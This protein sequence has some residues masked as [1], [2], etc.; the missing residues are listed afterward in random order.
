[1][2]QL[3]LVVF[4]IGN[5]E[6]FPILKAPLRSRIASNILSDDAI[7][8]VRSESTKLHDFNLGVQL[9]EAQL[10]ISGILERQLT[11]VSPTSL[12]LLYIA[13][14]LTALSPCCLSLLPL[15]LG[16]LNDGP[17]PSSPVNTNQDVLD[18]GEDGE[19]E[20]V[21][22][23]ATTTTTTTNTTTTVV[24]D[25]KN[26]ISVVEKSIYYALGFA[27]ALTT[28]GF[29]ATTFGQVFGAVTGLSTSGQGGL[30]WSALFLG[31]LT[32][33]MGCNLLEVLNI[34][35][36]ALPDDALDIQKISN[37]RIQPL[38]L[39]ASAAVIAS[40]CASPV[41]ASILAIL[42]STIASQ[43]VNGI[44]L[45]FTYSIGYSSP[46]ILAGILSAKISEM[47]ANSGQFLWVNQALGIALVG[48]GTH[49]MLEFVTSVVI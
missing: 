41:L 18:V 11:G 19:G 32:F 7:F 33:L 34:P 44:V 22:T 42:S 17:T 14:L 35:L 1:M 6:P 4:L 25:N 3:L 28:L 40:P 20:M 46:I 48:F 21:T 39:G 13:G 31:S 5:S 30:E 2:F 37:A 26:S 12:S 38:I 24:T 47:S 10:S 15:T 49:S 23:T 36:P 27:I 16:Y 43:P 9:Y 45:L 8:R 29:I